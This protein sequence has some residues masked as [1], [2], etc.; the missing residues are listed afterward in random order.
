MR[1]IEAARERARRL[2]ELVAG[3]EVARGIALV[4]I[5]RYG[6]R[7]LTPQA[8]AEVL[9]LHRGDLATRAVTETIAYPLW[10]R[11]ARVEASARTLD[12]CA[13]TV[14]CTVVSNAVPG[15]VCLDAGNKA[16]TSDRNALDL[17]SGF[18]HVVEYPQAKIVRLSEEHG[19][20]DITKCDKAPKLGERVRVIPNH[21]CPCVNLQDNA[22]LKVGEGT[23]E[24]LP[25]DA[26]GKLS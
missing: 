13:A 21:I 6:A 25:I 14:Y 1:G 23:F 9:V 8:E 24:K 10:A 19:E 11:G 5:G 4:A 20:V 7:E 18:G 12:E 22:W 26:R 16:L 17:D 2:D 3:L 15:R